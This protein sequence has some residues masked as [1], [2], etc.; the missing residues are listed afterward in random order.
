MNKG[1]IKM[2]FKLAL[3]SLV[4]SSSVASANCRVDPAYDSSGSDHQGRWTF[5]DT[6]TVTT[7]CDDGSVSTEK[8]SYYSDDI[9]EGSDNQGHH[10]TIKKS[11]YGGP[12]TIEEH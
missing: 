8:P 4:L 10:W 5:Y 2:L 3:L 11:P 1:F 7:R 12:D 6:G 9:R